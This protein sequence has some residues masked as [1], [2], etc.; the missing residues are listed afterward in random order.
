MAIVLPSIVSNAQVKAKG[1]KTIM[2]IILAS[3]IDTMPTVPVAPTTLEESVTITGDIVLKAGKSFLEVEIN[4][5]SGQLTTTLEGEIQNK[6]WRNSFSFRQN[7]NGAELLGFYEYFKNR[8]IVV[9]LR[10]L[11]GDWRLLG[12]DCSRTTLDAAVID[13][14]IDPASF[15]GVQA[16]VVSTGDLAP[17]F[18]GAI[19]VSP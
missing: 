6:S 10:E 12:G 7:G 5:D 3:D 15:K 16:T 19:T 11:C 18:T 8:E 14:G 13:T 9:L 2:K 17:I 1:I 4:M